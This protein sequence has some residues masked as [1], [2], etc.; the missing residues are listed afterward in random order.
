MLLNA[1]SEELGVRDSRFIG[2]LPG[3]F[4]KATASEMDSLTGSPVGHSDSGA[5]VV[6]HREQ[7]PGVLCQGGIGE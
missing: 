6:I 7:V 5:K 3:I 2:E 1:Y 4:R